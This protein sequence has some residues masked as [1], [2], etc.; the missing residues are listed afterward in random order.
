[1]LRWPPASGLGEHTGGTL[2]FSP[3]A[4]APCP[5]YCDSS[6]RELSADFAL[7]EANVEGKSIN[8]C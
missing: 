8:M 3:S 5:S 7:V 4:S 2:A 6:L 1:M